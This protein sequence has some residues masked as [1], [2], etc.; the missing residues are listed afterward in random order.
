MGQ[1]A[2]S[3]TPWLALGLALLVG[4][5]IRICYLVELSGSP[6][7]TAPAFDAAFHD[8]WAKALLSGDWA[9]P[10]F[11]ADPEI[12]RTPY[13]RPPAYPHFLAAVYW[14]TDSS[15]IG[16]RAAQMLLGLVNIVLGFFAGRALFHRGVGIL[17]AWGLSCFWIFPYFEGE[18]LAPVLLV[19]LVLVQVLVW[20]RWWHQGGWGWSIGG[21]LLLG[22]FALAR[23]NALLLAPVIWLWALWV[24]RHKQQPNRTRAALLGILI[25][26]AIAIA[27]ATIR[28]YSVASD[29]VLI[30]SNGGINLYIGNNEKADGYSARIPMMDE[31]AALQGWTCFDQPKIAR[32]VSRMLD[33]PLA[34]SEVSDYFADVAF[35][36]ILAH[37]GDTL[38][39]A[40]KKAAL[41]WGPAEISN[42]RQIQIARDTSWVLR[43]LPSFPWV[44]S[45]ALL[46]IALLIS[47]LRGKTNTH[48]RDLSILLLAIIAVF[49]AS[50]LPFFVAGRYRVPLIPLLIVFGAYGVHRVTQMLRAREGARAARWITAWLA[51]LIAAH[52]QF[53]PYSAD[54]GR[55]HFQRGEAFRMSGDFAAA[56]AEHRL[57]IARDATPEPNAYN[58]LAAVL[59][60]TQEFPEAIESLQ[61]ALRMDPSYVAAHHN[62]GL[63]YA[64]TG[65]PDLA[66]GAFERALEL[67]PERADIRT[68]LGGLLLMQMNQPQEALVQLEHAARQSG[69]PDAV[70]LYASALADVGRTRDAIAV[71]ES[72][73][74]T[75]SHPPSTELLRSLR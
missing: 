67:D 55:W 19:T 10:Q 50:H 30:T 46:G 37:P 28:N 51:L 44:W 60:Q 49:F 15:P 54:I 62:L 12:D 35:D 2:E 72:L 63:A 20:H 69:Q 3:R 58:N 27:P 66:I 48:R 38:T 74:R 21:G 42:N 7:V 36:H 41:F 73:L 26:I 25:G 47:D 14:L 71:L 43:W 23:P 34:A 70:Y 65:R 53:V 24:A 6:E 64:N 56:I 11:F 1:N 17:T 68:Q 8:F 32:G 29:F 9:A 5:I 39:L 40:A 31:I 18:L 57:A 13:F 4:A 52:F 33:R 61:I 75:T 22:L 45:L 16:A 59:M